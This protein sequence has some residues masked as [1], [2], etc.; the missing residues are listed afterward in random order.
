MLGR[1][2]FLGHC[3]FYEPFYFQTMSGEQIAARQ[4]LVRTA[5]IYDYASYKRVGG[6]GL[7][8]EDHPSN[9]QS[10]FRG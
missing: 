3:R 1:R 7:E 5:V 6:I 4:A 10:L 9:I 8:L 2:F